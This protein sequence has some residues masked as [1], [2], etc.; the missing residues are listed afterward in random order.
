MNLS[1]EIIEDAELLYGLNLANTIKKMQDR[2]IS[3]FSNVAITISA[4]DEI[5]YRLIVELR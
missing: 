5:P 3:K 2:A 4:P 1:A